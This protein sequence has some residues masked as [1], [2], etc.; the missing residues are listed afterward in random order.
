MN[1]ESE[2]NQYLND[3]SEQLSESKQ[4]EKEFTS[5]SLGGALRTLG[6]LACNMEDKTG[7]LDFLAG[8][9]HGKNKYVSRGAI[10]AIGLLKDPRGIPILKTFTGKDKYDRRQAT[11]NAALKT[12]NKHAELV[13]EEI[14]K[15]RDSLEE[16]RNE[17]A[18][19]GTGE[20]QPRVFVVL[21]YR[22]DRATLGEIVLNQ[23]PVPAEVRA[24]CDVRLVAAGFVVV[25]G[26]VHGVGVVPR[27]LNVG[28]ERRV[29]HPA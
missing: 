14:S 8:Y 1:E 23:F 24:L 3:M 11:A 20:Q 22:V 29:R 9:T 4:R 16:L 25:E 7:V 17:N 10:Q 15:I 27:R 5:R 6:S 13:P 26:N 2:M 18:E 12:L 21:E 28:N 19:L